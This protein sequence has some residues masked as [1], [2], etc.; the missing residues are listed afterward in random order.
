[1]NS[2]HSPSLLYI[3]EIDST[4]FTVLMHYGTRH[5]TAW[6]GRVNGVSTWTIEVRGQGQDMKLVL[7]KS[8]KT[9][10]RTRTNFPAVM[11]FRALNGLSPPYLDQLVRVADLPGR[12]RLRSSS[13]RWLQVS[14]YRLATVGR[15]SFPVSASILWNSLTPD[16]QSCASIAD[17]YTLK[18][19]LFQQSFLHTFCCSY[20][21]IDFAIVD[22]VTIPGY[23]SHVS[24]SDLID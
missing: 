18:T 6:K 13:S 9:R 10:T 8:L 14:A 21:H 16:I 1:L 15:H 11:A 24:N 4:V 7:K 5:L 2:T 22:Y 19:Y 3:A 12:H 17:F 20:T 23:S